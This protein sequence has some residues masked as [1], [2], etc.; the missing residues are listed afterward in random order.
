ME[1]TF[2]IQVD[3][4]D[5]PIGV[6]EKMKAHS[7]GILHRAFS[8]FVFTWDGKFLLQKRAESK[9]HSASL[10]TNA[11]CGHPLPGEETLL[12][13]TRRLD[14][15]MGM[16]C[17]LQHA[18][19]F[20]YKAYLSNGLVENE[21]D[22]VFIGRSDNVPS[23]NPA[24]VSDWKCVSLLELKQ[25]IAADGNSYTEWFKMIFESVYETYAKQYG[26]EQ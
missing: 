22:H 25:Q 6:I 19:H 23:P 15:E 2:L 14:Y 24:E 18:F 16:D 7:E 11:C 20:E 3:E 21:V 13:A 9:Y 4:K 12:A 17:H 5:N 10:W 26:G 8:V 1:K